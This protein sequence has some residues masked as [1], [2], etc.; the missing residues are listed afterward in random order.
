MMTRDDGAMPNFPV[1]DQPGPARPIDSERAAAL[2]LAVLDEVVLP[3]PAPTLRVISL[4]RRRRW[5]LLGLAA[6]LAFGVALAAVSSEQGR[7][8]TTPLALSPAAPPVPAMPLA[9]QAT[10][11]AQVE[12]PAQV[13]PPQ[14][15]ETAPAIAPGI[16]PEVSKAASPRKPS[17]A[18][19]TTAPTAPSSA[20]VRP[21]LAPE[22]LLRAAN[23]LRAEHRW[24]EAEQTYQRVIARGPDHAEAYAA[25]IAAASIRLEHLGDARGAL[26]LYRATA[27]AGNG[28][29]VEEADWGIAECYRALGDRDA[30]VSAL[31][32]FVGAHPQSALRPTAE[33]RLSAL[34]VD[35]APNP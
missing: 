4:P 22:D 29:L 26:Q 31:R 15:P 19:P 16:A 18:D 28:A 2:V 9:T 8:P 17:I 25:S 27:R 33:A 5:I 12:P 11:P 7:A 23:R 30:E 34:G 13:T 1:D 32:T 3:A 20:V 24:A 10:Q 21:E 6:T 35:S 14:A